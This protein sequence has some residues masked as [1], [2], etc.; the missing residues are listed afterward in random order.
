MKQTTTRTYFGLLKALLAA[1]AVALTC[2]SG[3]AAQESHRVPEDF[4]TIQLAI[5]A[6]D[7]G[8][9]VLVAPGTYRERI[10][11]KKNVTLRSIGE[12]EKGKLGLRRAEDTIID[13]ELD[14][15]VGPGVDMAEG[16]TLDGFTVTGVGSYDESEWKKHHLT[17]GEEQTHE[18]IGEPGVAGI[19][20]NGVTCSVSNNI[21]HHIGYS[22]IAVIGVEGKR[23]APHLYRNICYRNMG[24]GIGVMKEATGV[25][26]ENLCFENF[27][28]GIGHDHAHPTVIKN[29][30]H[31]NIRAGI[32]IS[33]GA[34]PI[35][36]SNQC[37]QN[38]RAGIGIRTGSDTRPVV[39][40]NDCYENDMAGIGVRDEAAPTIR[41]NHCYKN[42]LA[43]I[44]A[45]TGAAPMIV[46]NECYE[47]GAAGIG[48]QSGAAP[49]LVANHVH[50]NK[51]AGIGFEACESATATVLNNRVVENG[52]VAAGIHSG[53]TVELSGNFLTRKEGMPP[54]VMVF[55]GASATLFSNVINGGGVAG[56][57]VAGKVRASKNVISGTSLRLV[58]PPNFAIWALRGSE[59]EMTENRVEG[60]RHALHADEATV[61]ASHNSVAK[62]GGVAFSI[63][64]PTAPADVFSNTATSDE[65]SAK[66]L[67]LEGESGIVKDNHLELLENK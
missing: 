13:G 12:D 52:T 26:E 15:A 67:D 51:S 9:V 5:D 46:Y 58:G 47:N 42:K 14:G 7:S 23:C 10:R 20:I 40:N 37:Y 36:R 11:L 35:V 38:R 60:W 16:A 3:L 2:A 39:Q 45:R 19:A 8:D 27:F 50:H 62:F 48:L 1:V 17:Q 24:G 25:I 61:L 29:V 32:G 43:G 55:E 33:E 4:A 53:W 63:R 66:L 18:A 34:C 57:R 54:I 49:T 59:V 64:N 28:A 22:G 21:V 6:A 65:S 44:G 41:D 56:I 30:C 31:S